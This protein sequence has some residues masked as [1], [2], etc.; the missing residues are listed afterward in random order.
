M[1][2]ITFTI[3]HI[4]GI[5]EMLINIETTTALLTEYIPPSRIY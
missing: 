1:Y 4:P 5:L 3:W 2:D